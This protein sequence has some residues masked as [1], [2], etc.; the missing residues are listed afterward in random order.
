MKFNKDITAWGWF[1]VALILVVTGIQHTV[2]AE[3]YSRVRMS[4][5]APWLQG[6]P[7]VLIG[8][9]EL[10]FGLALLYWIIKQRH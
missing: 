6:W 3:L 7:V 2:T 5:D 9:A 10:L 4:G 8:I 1:I